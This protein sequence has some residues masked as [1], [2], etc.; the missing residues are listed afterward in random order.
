MGIRERAHVRTRFPYLGNGWKD[1]AENRCVVRGPLA[2]YFTQG[3]VTFASALI[4]VAH[5][6]APARSS[7]IRRLTGFVVCFYVHK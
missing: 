2:I 6:S 1:R 3:G 4:T 7:T 5:L